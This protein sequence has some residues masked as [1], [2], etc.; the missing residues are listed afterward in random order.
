MRAHTEQNERTSGYF[1]RAAR[2]ADKYRA[3]IEMFVVEA[4]RTGTST[5]VLAGASELDFLIEFVCGR[6]GIAFVKTVDPERARSIG[7]R[8]GVLLLYAES[9]RLLPG[10]RFEKRVPS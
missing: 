4:K 2:N 7:R 3:M 1:R 10:C 8:L 9:E 6:H 5:L